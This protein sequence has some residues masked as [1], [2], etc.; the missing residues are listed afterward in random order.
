MKTGLKWL[1][2]ACA[3]VLFGLGEGW[4]AW[5][6]DHPNSPRSL[7]VPESLAAPDAVVEPGQLEQNDYRRAI[8]DL[9]WQ[10]EGTV[11]TLPAGA[12]SWSWPAHPPVHPMP[13][14]GLGDALELHAL[15]QTDGGYAYSSAA[16][17]VSNQFSGSPVQD[18]RGE[19][20]EY[21][22]EVSWGRDS[23]EGRLGL[24]AEAELERDWQPFGRRDEINVMVGAGYFLLKND[25]A[26]LVFG[27]AGQM[28]LE[29]EPVHT[30]AGERARLD[31]ATARTGF[32]QNLVVNVNPA[33]TLRGGLRGLVDPTTGENL[34]LRFR[35]GLEGHFFS[36]LSFGVLYSFEYEADRFSTFTREE[37]RVTTRLAYRF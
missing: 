19:F 10:R 24:L 23:A 15:A 5:A 36:S 18:G 2:T 27:M 9:E 31:S 3:T 21:W 6:G 22:L 29:Q 12:A 20:R 35:A 25:R 28:E 33:L 1:A 4:T 34:N 13:E 30:P 11:E 26:E 14:A 16:G 17:S 37:N 8:P 32:F 7:W